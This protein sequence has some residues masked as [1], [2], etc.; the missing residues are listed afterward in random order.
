LIGPHNKAGVVIEDR[1]DE[2]VLP[3]VQVSAV[4][5]EYFSV[6]ETPL[7]EGRFFSEG[8]DIESP[9]AAVVDQAM[10]QR[11]WP[12]ENPIGKQIKFGRR[13]SRAPWIS[14]VGVVG[15]I[16]TDGFDVPEQPHVYL[17]IFQNVGYAM[18]V[19]VK[20]EG[21][22][23]SLTQALRQQVQAVDPDLPVFGEKTMED[24]VAS[25]LAKR[26]F[27][28]RLVTVFGVVALL[29]A[30]IGIYGVM[31]YSVN[32]RSREIG[33]RLALGAHKRDIMGWV[34]KQGMWLTTIGVTSGL[35]GAFALTRL[36][37]GLLFDVAATDA[38][39]Y[40]ALSLLLAF[41]AFVACYIPARR[42]TKV[43][44]M[45]SLRCE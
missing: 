19:Y 38:L 25:S 23:R 15:N 4:S 3:Q 42:A 14:V 34:L 29:L 1:A 22:P 27:S 37:E 21:N 5:S 40:A 16:K 31:A 6:L 11:F 28:M 35:A 17:P 10:V 36:L 20:T 8:D 41:V 32:Q 9:K 13:D 43:D 26:R 33:I 24:L 12:S 18:V 30:G 44:P 45:I 39:T 2:T 7:M